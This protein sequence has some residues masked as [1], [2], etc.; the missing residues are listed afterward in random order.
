MSITFSIEGIEEETGDELPCP[1]CKLSFRDNRSGKHSPMEC[2]CMGYGG[3][4]QL[5]QPQF[6]MNVANGNAYALLEAIGQTPDYCGE[7]DPR[8]VLVGLERLQPGAL[9]SADEQ[10]AANVYC[11]GRSSEQVAR[12]VAQLRKIALKARKYDRRVVWG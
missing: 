10:P 8:D 11:A 3:P 6:E 9:E 5:P 1:Q 2:L 7:V 12:Y 4:E